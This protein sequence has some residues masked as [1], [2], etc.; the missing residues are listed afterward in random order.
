MNVSRNEVESKPPSSVF[1]ET[2]IYLQL[3]FNPGIINGDF[4][5]DVVRPLTNPK[6]TVRGGSHSGVGRAVDQDKARAAAWVWTL[7]ALAAARL[8]QCEQ[9]EWSSVQVG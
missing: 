8:G 9:R 3:A 7:A 6:L 5:R 2:L 1:N 4:S